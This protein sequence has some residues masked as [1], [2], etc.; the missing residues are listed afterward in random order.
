MKNMAFKSKTELI[1]QARGKIEFAIVVAIFFSSLFYMASKAGGSNDIQSN[2]N[3][4]IWG[5]AVAFHIL[6]YVLIDLSGRE[7]KKSLFRWIQIFLV[8]GIL[9]FV[10][11]IF[12]AVLYYNKSIPLAFTWVFIGSLTV[13]LAMPVLTFF[14]ICGHLDSI[15]IKGFWKM[16]KTHL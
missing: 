11:A 9:A 14:L 4:L 1:K 16:I 5:V 3:A 13:A 8:L 12:I 10:P 15:A 2:G 7:I 6:N